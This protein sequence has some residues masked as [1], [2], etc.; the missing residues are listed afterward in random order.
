MF[1]LWRVQWRGPRA[2]AGQCCNNRSRSGSARIR[3]GPRG[4]V[5]PRL[6]TGFPRQGPAFERALCLSAREQ[7]LADLAELEQLLADLAELEQLLADLAELE[8]L[9]AD[10]AELEQLLADLAELEQLYVK[11]I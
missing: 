10:L 1:Y 5:A 8:Q 2:R 4:R 11:S 7:L 9:L 3:A 6:P